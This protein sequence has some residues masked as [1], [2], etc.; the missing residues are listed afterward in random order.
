MGRGAQQKFKS[1]SETFAGRSQGE[2]GGGLRE[3]GADH[4]PA[5]HCGAGESS[6]G[7]RRH[8]RIDLATARLRNKKEG[9]EGLRQRDDTALV[10]SPNPTVRR[11]LAVRA[12]A[13]L[14]FIAIQNRQRIFP[15]GGDVRRFL[16]LRHTA[17]AARVI[18]HLIRTERVCRT[19]RG[20]AVLP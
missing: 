11:N 4:P 14:A 7:A 3:T 9:C 18:A 19:S 15:N 8:Q 16:M 20:L 12:N 6:A 5:D 1:S 13:A 10:T 17:Q 2:A